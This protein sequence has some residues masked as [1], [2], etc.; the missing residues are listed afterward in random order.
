MPRIAENSKSVAGA[1]TQRHGR[2]ADTARTDE[3]DQRLAAVR[4]VGGDV[5]VREVAINSDRRSGIGVHSVTTDTAAA[6]RRY[7]PKTSL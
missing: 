4:T 1:V 5:S 7:S 6:R 2:V 3:R